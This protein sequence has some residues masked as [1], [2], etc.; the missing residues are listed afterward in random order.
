MLQ[1]HVA[2]EL[3]ITLSELRTRMTD[4]EVLGWNAFYNIRAEQERKA[5]EAAKRRR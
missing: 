4:I 2:N 5:I 1:F 3:G